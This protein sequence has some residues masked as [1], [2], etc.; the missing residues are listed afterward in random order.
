M[1]M[2]KVS[3]I[4]LE[5]TAS[6]QP[7]SNLNVRFWNQ[8]VNTAELR[9]LITRNNFPLSL[10]KENV[11]IIIALEQ[12]ENFISSEDFIVSSEVDGVASFLIPKDFMAAAD[13]EVTGQVFVGTIDGN[14]TLVQRKFSFEV[15]RDLLSKIPTEEKIKYIKTFDDLK[16]EIGSRLGSI[17]ETLSTL[18][19]FISEI[20][21]TTQKGVD[22]LT[23]LFNSQTL[24]FNNNYDEKYNTINTIKTDIESYVTTAKADMV[25]KKKEFDEAV[26]ASGLVTEV[27]AK[28][29][30]KYKLT[31]DDGT[32]VYLSK[33]SFTDVNQLPPG[34]YE[35]VTADDASSQGFPP[36]INDSSFV[37][38]DVTKGGSTR[39][40]IK[41]VMNYN[42]KT[43]CKTIHTNGADNYG[44]KEVPYVNA[45]DPFETI[46]GSKNK[47]NA[48][49]NNAK[50]YTDERVNEQHAVLFS[51][52]TNG[53]NKTVNLTGS[54]DDYEYI[55]VS[56]DVIGN[57]FS[58][59]V[60]P[61]ISGS[62]VNM[63]NMNLR[64]SDGM[65]LGVYEVRLETTSTTIKIT[66]DVAYD[67]ITDSG[68]G[69]GRNAWTI[70]R[71]EG[72]M[73]K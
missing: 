33:G 64:D 60:V 38:I 41:V 26:L 8:D 24:T 63:Q 2:T 10:S 32:R 57:D 65:L 58:Q 56:G 54:M 39:T 51:G 13:G 52:S 23:S 18:E 7:L 72:V 43:F 66:N 53:V 25:A 48:A 31:N 70:T 47:A 55:I 22:E 45:A 44:W 61:S 69:Q 42:M 16:L 36:G 1:A 35:T 4:N 17:E 19:N 73:K 6:Y 12:G 50:L 40:Q 34:F 37:E 9:F 67:N 46:T 30:Q 20:E 27:D 62:V 28:N 3:N 68:S 14:R 11:K 5:T 15:S 21:Y 71:V 49:E 29:W 59:I